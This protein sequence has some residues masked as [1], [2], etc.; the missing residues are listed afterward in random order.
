MTRYGDLGKT[1]L[2]ERTLKA[3]LERALEN[4]PDVVAV[5]DPD[6][7]MTYAELWEAARHL[8]GGFRSA[9]VER[10]D[11]VAMVLGSHLDNVLT[12]VALSLLGAVEVPV[13]TSFKGEMLAYI[14][15]NSGARLAVV[16]R[17]LGDTFQEVAADLANVESVVLRGPVGDGPVDAAGR[18]ARRTFELAE[19]AEHAPADPVVVDPWDLL[20][21]MYTS[22]TTGRSKG[23]L[24]P[25]A[26][27]WNHASGVGT[28]EPGDVRFVVL[29]QF[30]IAGQWGG[31]YRALLAEATAYVAPGFHVSTFW[32]EIR[33]VGATTTQL[34]GTMAA[35]LAAQDPTPAEV[36]N[37]LR[38]I[39]MIP[40]VPDVEAFAERFG[41]SVASGFG[42]T[43]VGTV[44]AKTDA[45][46]EPGL[47][48]VREGYV[49]RIVD[50]H[51]MEVPQGQ[52]GEFV[53]RAELP[54]TTMA[55]Y[56]DEPEK[57]A[58][59]LRNGWLHSGDAVY[60]DVEGHFYFADR[61]DDAIRRRGENVSSLEVELHVN[62]HPAV[63]E[64]AVVAVPSEYLED[65]IKAVVVLREGG[66]ASEEDLFLFLADRLPYFMVP[67]YVELRSELPKTP[68]AKVRKARLREDG[69]GG[70]WD[71]QAA[72]FVVNRSGLTTPQTA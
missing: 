65:E 19:L 21:I 36:D 11:R 55:G 71:S 29:P 53:V 47:G 20:G 22:G 67:R 69:L 46:H 10:G 52:P 45:V 44:L 39:H 14:V 17:A 33:S 59:V 34:V 64:S 40:V 16:D 61:V 43:E 60:Q 30:H 41:V 38:E 23:V 27:A 57:T 8:A 54:W 4:A 63:L 31:V 6:R 58:E 51:D 12:W 68:T 3:V 26:H 49:V 25:H 50:E 9:G 15:N 18:A 32:E 70:A 7:S 56:L 2:E 28:T 5:R 66:A 1:A 48:S 72:G 13:N 35:F 62:Q 42:N 24:A 37:T